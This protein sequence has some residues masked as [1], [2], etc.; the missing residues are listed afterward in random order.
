MSG[1]P[2]TPNRPSAA[3][4]PARRN[5]FARYP[6]TT[7]LVTVL[8]L[9][10]LVEL[11]C[12]LLIV[13]KGHRDLRFQYP[14]NRILSGYTVFQNVPGHSFRTSAI[15]ADPSE[16][17][18]V[19]DEH[20]FLHDTPIT[21]EKPPG[22]FRIFLMGGSTAFGAGQN[23]RYHAV[24]PYPDGLYAY[25]S[26]IAGQLQSYLQ[27]HNPPTH[28]E[29]I[30]AAGFE[31]RIHQSLIQ[32]I[33]T[34]SQFQPDLIINLDGMND[35][36]S[37]VTGT[38]FE[39]LDQHLPFYVELYQGQRSLLRYSSTYYVLSTLYSKWVNRQR[40]AEPAPITAG[41]TTAT[42]AKAKPGTTSTD[43]T[44][45]HAYYEKSKD[46]YHKNAERL[47]QIVR[48]YFAV[49]KADGTPSI[50]VLQPLLNRKRQ[51]KH[52]SEIERKLAEVMVPA[53]P[54]TSGSVDQCALLLS[55]FYDDFLSDALRK[56]AKEFGVPYLDL[57]AEIA[58]LGSNV[59]FYTDYCHLTPE[60]NRRVAEILGRAILA[61]NTSKNSA[62]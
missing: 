42:P 5:R 45:D 33:E 3:A 24:H 57:N 16:P 61:G 10:G 52:L 39:D 44:S 2:E 8:V 38:P 11:G 55:Y 53:G 59:E 28:Y 19:L 58:P 37:L 50:F 35:V 21:R 4:V 51:N 12:Y 31:R 23:I 47:L 62:N 25:P 6:K 32:Y 56:T 54:D 29:V 1:T 13:I 49:L 26:S 14:Y 20:G 40:S 15:K 48:Q 30:N 41:S 7:L 22:T 43:D 36:Y 17:D 18:P 60:G 27:A 9:L 34:L 46:R